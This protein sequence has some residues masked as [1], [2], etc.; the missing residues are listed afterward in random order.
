MMH[1]VSPTCMTGISSVTYKPPSCI[2]ILNIVPPPS[3]Q[4]QAENEFYN[5]NKSL[6]QVFSSNLY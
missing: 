3:V 1:P 5:V 2:E 4:V 6:I